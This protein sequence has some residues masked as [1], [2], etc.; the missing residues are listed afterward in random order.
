MCTSRSKSASVLRLRTRLSAHLGGR[1]AGT[2]SLGGD[3]LTG[4]GSQ[5]EAA[6]LLLRLLRTSS[7]AGLLAAGTDS[8]GTSSPAGA[9][10]GVQ[11]STLTAHLEGRVVV[12]F[13]AFLQL[14]GGASRQSL[15]G[16]V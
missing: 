1:A 14:V 2:D 7:M 9:P 8:P 6:A 4:W 3:K 5:P 15:A 10:S 13:P 11:Q 16:E 12:W